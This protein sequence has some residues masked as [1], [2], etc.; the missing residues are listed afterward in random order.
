MRPAV[1]ARTRQSCGH[2]A[3]R[4]ALA[5]S[6]S[7]RPEILPKQSPA[8]GP[9]RE[10]N[11]SRGPVPSTSS[12]RCVLGRVPQPGLLNVASAGFQNLNLALD[13]VLQSG[14][15]EAE[16]VDVLDLDL[17]AELFLTTRTHA[18]IGVAT[19]RAFFHV[20]VRNAAVKQDFLEAR[21]VLE[22]LVRGADIGLG[23]NLGQWR[24]AAVQVEIGARGGVDKAVVEALAGVLFHVQ[25]GDADAFCLSVRIWYVNPAVLCQGFVELG[26]LV[27]P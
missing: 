11:D 16:A 5:A 2:G 12:N 22:G 3:L 24:A 26:D 8:A 1:S 25:A 4:A 20:A 23:D 9:A 27:T 19:Q 14:A 6:F 15:D 21:E 13:L 7:P 18:Y 10:S 17:G